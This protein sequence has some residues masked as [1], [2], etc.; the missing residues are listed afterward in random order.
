MP[1]L[2]RNWFKK[3]KKDKMNTEKLISLKEN[4]TGQKFQWVKTSR[5]ELLGKVV[6]CRDVDFGPGG[7]FI[8]MFDDGSKIESTRLNSDLLM[9][10]GDMQPLTKDEVASIYQAKASPKLTINQRPVEPIAEKIITPNFTPLEAKVERVN[11]SNM[12]EMFNSDETTISISLKVKLPDRK[13]L[14][15]MYTSAENKE[16]F[17][18]ELSEYLQTKINKHVI[19]ESMHAI[20]DPTPVKKETRPTINLRE[21][22]ESK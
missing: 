11:S 20:L 21:V 1:L 16:K 8:V 9:I 6:K 5:P 18:T 14:K 19:K 4:F 12:F 15:M 13:L 17:L 7:T 2:W 3:N 10:H 22:D